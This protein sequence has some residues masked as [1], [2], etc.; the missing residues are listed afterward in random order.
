ML[1]HP[2]AEFQRSVTSFPAM[3]CFPPAEISSA[4][5]LHVGKA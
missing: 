3:E 1:R 2:L 5:V 4:S